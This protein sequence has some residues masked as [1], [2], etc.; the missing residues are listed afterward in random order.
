MNHDKIAKRAAAIFLAGLASGCSSLTAENERG[1]IISHVSGLDRDKAFKLADDSCHK[2]GRV[3]R[4]SGT[5]TLDSTMT[6]DC[7]AP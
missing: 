5:N 1:G 7:V 3:A 2:Y 4:I 6:Y